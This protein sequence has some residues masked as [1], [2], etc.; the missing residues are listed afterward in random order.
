[1][2]N[3][4]TFTEARLGFSRPGRVDENMKA[5]IEAAGG[6]DTTDPTSGYVKTLN[7]IQARPISLD[8]VCEA[9]GSPRRIYRFTDPLDAA[10][11]EY[12]LEERA[13]AS[14]LYDQDRCDEIEQ[15]FGEGRDLLESFDGSVTRILDSLVARILLARKRG[16]GGASSGVTLGC[17]WLSPPTSWSATDFAEALYHETL[18]QAL[19]LE[20]MIRGVYRVDIAT[21]SAPDGQ[22]VSAIRKERRPF[23]ASFHAACVAAGL[24]DLYRF[25]GDRDRVDSLME[26]LGPSVDE[27]ASKREFLDE[28]GQAILGE[29]QL[30]VS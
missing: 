10:I 18:H 9:S 13:E 4:R 17:I 26:G 19:F 8:G 1:M 11:L 2:P 30:R 29:I 22:V 14:H 15:R 3:L 27:M 20:E 21:M 12:F 25:L 5:L 28:D 16:F 24:I 23:G 6:E 7:R